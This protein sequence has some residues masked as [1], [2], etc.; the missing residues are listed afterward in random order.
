MTIRVPRS[1]MDPG[2]AT[3]RYFAGAGLWSGDG[4][5]QVATRSQPTTDAPASGSPIVG[6]PA[7]FNLAFRF[8]EPQTNGGG[9]PYTTAPG[10]GNWFEDAQ[11]V[12]LRNRTSGGFHSDVDFGRLKSQNNRWLHKPGLKQAR[13]YASHYQPYEGLRAG[14]PGYGTRLQPYMVVLP[15][16]HVPRR[17]YPLTLAL[18]AGDSSYTQY[19]VYDTNL[20][21][22]LGGQRHSIVVTPFGRGGDTTYTGIGEAD[23]FEAWGS[24]AR[25]LRLNPRRVAIAGYSIG[26]YGAYRLGLHYPDLFGRAFTAV[27]LPAYLGWTPPAPPVPGGQISNVYELLR[28]AR[29]VPYLDWAQASDEINPYPGPRALQ[30]RF[31]AL[32]L[33]SQLWTFTSG[34]HFLLSILDE[35]GGARDF[36]GR[37]RVKRDPYRL[38]YAFL[39]E[40]ETPRL[41]L[42]QDHAYWVSRLRARNRSGDPQTDPAV[43]AVDARS[44]AFGRRD[45][46]TRHMVSSGG[47]AGPPM[48]SSIDST[49][50][51]H[52]RTGRTRN[53]LSVRFTN[54]A[55]ATVDGCRAWLSNTKPLVIR[56]TSDGR[57]SLRLALPLGR[58]TTVHRHGA[59]RGARTGRRGAV[60]R[61]GRGQSSFVVRSPRRLSCA[62]RA[63]P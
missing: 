50:W 58:R 39:P 18:H 35:W 63:R 33:R 8:H 1:I 48:P 9:P 20:Y 27:G 37:A 4:W 55:S 29:W 21:R 15:S 34:D 44:D 54:V 47:G 17:G 59:A 26:G 24:L 43:A 11:A 3:W 53:R 38:D 31:N 46:I 60:L 52:G 7:V 61:F 41:G 14:F 10:I 28:N 19:A 13:I 42:R 2:D 62:R 45:P 16:A 51:T 5:Q 6:A 40:A 23:V 57:G 12:A 22:Q 25:S 36:L 30:D 56:A 32:G 49:K